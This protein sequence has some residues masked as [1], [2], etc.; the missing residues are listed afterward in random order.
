MQCATPRLR[1]TQGFQ[2]L[3]R[4]QLSLIEPTLASKLHLG[5]VNELS[6]IS[7]TQ[8]SGE[9]LFLSVKN[10]PIELKA[11]KITD[12][13]MLFPTS[14]WLHEPTFPRAASTL[15]SVHSQTG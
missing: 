14:A 10:K 9:F 8:L 13:L 12:S 5:R 7:T 1:S 6:L 15:S 4:Y 2:N 3:L 11:G